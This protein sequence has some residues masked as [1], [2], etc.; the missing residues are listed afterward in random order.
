VGFHHGDDFF[1]IFK[2][3]FKVFITG[4]LG[5]G[6][7][8][9][10][11]ALADY[12][13]KEGWV[14]GVWSNIDHNLPPATRMHR[15]FV[16]VDETAD[17]ADSRDFKNNQH[18]LY[19]R[20]ARKMS[21]WYAFPSVDAI[22]IRLRN[23]EVIRTMN[24]QLLPITIWVFRWY[25]TLGDRGWFILTSPEDYFG[26]Y[27]T[28]AVPIGDGGVTEAIC[29]EFPEAIYEILQTRNKYKRLVDL[30]KGLVGSDHAQSAFELSF[31][32]Q[33]GQNMQQALDEIMQRLEVLENGL[34]TGSAG[35]A[36]EGA[37]VSAS[38]FR[39]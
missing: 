12:F 28:G 14:D 22:D 11:F 20:Y 32:Q 1:E 39:Y 6:K 13:L 36:Q 7:T 35:T 37:S 9:L 33:P 21:C 17:S 10:A 34:A 31:K 15:A 2:D 19:S 3:T 26:M 4:E 25:Y 16:V 23:L 5:T 29:A 18:A 8:L 24:I 27:E 38:G 30:F